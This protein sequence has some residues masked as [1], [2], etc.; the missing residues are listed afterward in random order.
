MDHYKLVYWKTGHCEKAEDLV[1]RRQI[2]SKE[3]RTLTIMV[4]V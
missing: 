4:A 1:S 2:K 3:Q